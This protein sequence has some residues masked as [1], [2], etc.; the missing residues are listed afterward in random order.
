MPKDAILIVQQLLIWT[1]DDYRLYWLLGELLN[2]QGEPESAK[3]VFED[4][5]NKFA[6]KKESGLQAVYKPGDIVP[7]INPERYLAEF[8]ATYPQVGPQ[9]QALH[10]YKREQPADVQL[11]E[12]KNEQPVAPPPPAPDTSVP[13]GPPVGALVVDWQTLAVGF[14]SGLLAGVFVAWQW[15][16]LRRRRLVRPL[17]APHEMSRWAKPT[18]ASDSNL[19]PEER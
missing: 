4:F 8:V 16:E 15:R 6:Q 10:N 11:I 7:K 18:G 3:V 9:V 13:K 12:P 17:P 14:G 5:L 19:R 2:A 1:P